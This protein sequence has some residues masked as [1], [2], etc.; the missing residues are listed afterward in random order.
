MEQLGAAQKSA[1]ETGKQ[2][3]EEGKSVNYIRSNFFPGDASC[4]CLFE[5]SDLET[6]KQLNERA[7]LPYT[8]ITEVMDLVP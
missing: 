6:V 1:I 8:E 7:N 2:M 5:A 4:T 3:S